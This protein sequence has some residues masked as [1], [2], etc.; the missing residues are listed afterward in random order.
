M[1]PARPDVSE[2]QVEAEAN[3]DALAGAAREGCGE[4]VVTFDPELGRGGSAG[5]TSGMRG[6]AVVGGMAA[7]A[8]AT[9]R[10]TSPSVEA[11]GRVLVVHC[12]PPRAVG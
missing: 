12:V 2:L 6:D 9:E 5:E 3:R 4:S 8:A 11:D 10:V 7:G 1:E